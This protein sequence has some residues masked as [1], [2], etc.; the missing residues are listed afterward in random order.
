MTCSARTAPKC[1]N[2]LKTPP[3]KLVVTES[4]ANAAMAKGTNVRNRYLLCIRPPY[5]RSAS[6]ESTSDLAA[7][8]HPV[9]AVARMIPQRETD[10]TTLVVR[11]TESVIVECF[12]ILCRNVEHFH[13]LQVRSE[14]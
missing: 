6:A 5:K 11:P 12:V 8:E 1:A 2:P 4:C 10:Y 3:L 13:L 9:N 14:E 7:R